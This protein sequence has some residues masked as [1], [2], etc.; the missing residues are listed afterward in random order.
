MDGCAF[1]RDDDFFNEL[2]VTEGLDWNVQRG[3]CLFLRTYLCL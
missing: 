2:Y 3:T 1:R